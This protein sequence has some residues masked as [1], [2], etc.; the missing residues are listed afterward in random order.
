M[1]L[2]EEYRRQRV[3]RFEQFEREARRDTVWEWL[4]A[5]GEVV[6]WTLAG[7][8]CIGLAFHTSDVR[9]GWVWWW[10]GF[11]VWIGGV[12]AAL[13]ATYRR[14]QARGDW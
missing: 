3:E 5:A 4:R 9:M 14:G 7:L 11:V 13:L 10:L 1:P 8:A 6:F 12:S 2:S